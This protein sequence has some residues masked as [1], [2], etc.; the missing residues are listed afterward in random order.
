MKS[1]W[2][3]LHWFTGCWH[4]AEEEFTEL[5]HGVRPNLTLIL[6]I[7]QCCKCGRVKS[8]TELYW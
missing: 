4:G 3:V 7:W 6:K 8:R 5:G 1:H 2:G